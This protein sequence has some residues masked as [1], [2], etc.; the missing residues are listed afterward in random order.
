MLVVGNKLLVD[1][2]KEVC[3]QQKKLYDRYDEDDPLE[4][5]GYHPL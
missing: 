5:W 2:W 3:L 4:S 1:V